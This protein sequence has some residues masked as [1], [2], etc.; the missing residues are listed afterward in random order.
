MS[1]KT[2]GFYLCK[3]RISGK[4]IED[5]N[6]VYFQN[7]DDEANNKNSLK[8]FDPELNGETKITELIFEVL[9]YL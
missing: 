8:Y 9:K 2:V 4:K 3:F 7:M 5:K 1:P 6:E